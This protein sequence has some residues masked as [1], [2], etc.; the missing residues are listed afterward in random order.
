[1]RRFSSSVLAA[2]G[3]A[4]GAQSMAAAQ[5]TSPT[6]ETVW[7]LRQCI[8]YAVKNNLQLRQAGL[9]VEQAAVDVQQAR[10][11]QLP[12]LNAGGSHGFNNGFFLDPV[13]NQIQNTQIWAGNVSLQSSVT[14][15]NGL[16]VQNT[17]K[18]NK[19]DYEASQYDKEKAENDI[20]L[21]VVTAYMQILLN[22]ELLRT[23]QERQNLSR[24][25]LE[26]TQ[27]LFNAGSV[28]ESNVLELNA[29]LA[30][31]ELNSITAQNNI[32]L[33][34]LRLIQLMNLENTDQRNFAIVAPEIEAPDQSVIGFEAQDVYERAED[35]MPEIKRAQLRVQS[36]AKTIDIARGGYYPSLNLVGSIS[37]RYSSGSNRF[38]VG[39]PVAVRR[40]I[41]FVDGTNQPVFAE[42]FVTETTP[43]D[44]PYFNQLN[45][46]IGQYIG[47]SLNIPILNGF[48]VRNNVQLSRIGLRNAELNTAIAKNDLRLIIAQSYTDAIAA[49]KRYVAAKSQLEAIEQTYRNAEIRL[50]NGL[51]NNVD[52]NVV[53]NN[54]VK[55]QSDIIQAKYEFVFKVK[56]LEFYQGKTLSL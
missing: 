37:T 7:D 35:V 16:Q 56:I 15:F 10:A 41:G 22:Q 26:R 53:R 21:N 20:K 24:I 51:I 25:Q 28:P 17:I 19:L 11:N 13:R 44:Y 47:V 40:Q 23:A 52:F 34:E 54:L 30:S 4:I 1:M 38:L 49:Q 46:N 3:L 32:E 6:G 36:A 45:D 29:Q 50:D 12:S 8:D 27:K 48:R 18:R 5:T 55:A 39:Q 9:G 2:L 14:V 43:R 31:D 42:T 33:A